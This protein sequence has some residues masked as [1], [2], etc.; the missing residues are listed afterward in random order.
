LGDLILLGVREIIKT[1]SLYYSV[2]GLAW[3][4]YDII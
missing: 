2:T 3:V 4:F 1:G